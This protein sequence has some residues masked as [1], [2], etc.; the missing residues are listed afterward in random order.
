MNQK[1]SRA[2]DAS[3]ALRTI[4]FGRGRR[5]RGDRERRRIQADRERLHAVLA[6]P[7]FLGFAVSEKIVNRNRVPNLFCL[8]FFVR[9]KLPESRLRG[10]ARIPKRLE[11]QS[12]QMRVLTDVQ[13]LGRMH[14]A[15]GSVGPGSLI[16]HMAG[17]AETVGTVT[18]IVK[19]RKDGAPLIM[20]CSHVLA[21]AGNA[22]KGD[23]VESPPDPSGEPGPNVVGHLTERFMV[24]DPRVLNKID[25]A[26]AEPIT[27]V[28]LSSDIPEIGSPAGVLDLDQMSPSDV[29]GMSVQKFGAQTQLTKGQITGLHATVK[30]R[31]P[32]LGDRVVLFTDLVTYEIEAEEGD[33]GAVVVQSE[34]RQIVGMH[35]AGG[36]GQ[37]VFTPIQP[38]LDTLQIDL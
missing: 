31:F 22:Q 30:I 3:M 16:G 5:P 1:Y 4:L 8:T 29:M 19:D 11:L 33:S 17:T 13:E 9:H 24:I 26:L 21:Q 27:G 10:G 23:P 35:I 12:A 15:H 37:C 20:G 14:V 2:R 32:V 36:G 7:N 28:P 38:V 6:D 25:A 34:K 18:L